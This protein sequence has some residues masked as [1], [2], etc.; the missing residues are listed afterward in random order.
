MGRDSRIT[1]RYGQ[2]FVRKF[3]KVSIPEL[4]N[5]ERAPVACLLVELAIEDGIAEVETLHLEGEGVTITGSGAIDLPQNTLDLRLVPTM[6]D[7]GLLSIAVTVNATGSL[8]D[9]DFRPLPRTFVTSALRGLL[10]NATRIGRAALRPVS[11]TRAPR[12][13]VCA[14]PLHA[15]AKRT[16]DVT[17]PPPRD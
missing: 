1:S 12:E 7:P 10:S 16:P 2:M 5:R 11:G 4:G 13:Q 3:I 15:S 9:P 17:S 14:S 6:R 8:T